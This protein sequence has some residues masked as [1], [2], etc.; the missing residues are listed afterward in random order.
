MGTRIALVM[1]TAG[2]LLA[3]TEPVKGQEV[4]S[5]VKIPPPRE[6]ISGAAA[7]NGLFVGPDFVFGAPGALFQG[8]VAEAAVG[9]S[10]EVATRQELGNFMTSL[11]V[12]AGIIV[13]DRTPD[14]SAATNATRQDGSRPAWTGRTPMALSL[15]RTR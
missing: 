5:D 9:A 6:L 1:V 12:R 2:S 4:N 7:I 13:F 10:S 3:F 11:M 8:S 15:S 14:R